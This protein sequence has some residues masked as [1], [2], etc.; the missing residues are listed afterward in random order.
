MKKASSIS[1][2]ENATIVGIGELLLDIMPVGKKLG[3]APANVA[4]NATF[5]GNKS[6]I[7]SCIGTDRNARQIIDSLQYPG[8][9]TSY[10]QQTPSLPTGTVEVS[11]D[12]HGEP[13]YQIRPNVAW[14]ALQWNENLERLSGECSGIAFGTLAQRSPQTRETICRFLQRAPSAVRLCDINLRMHFFSRDIIEN[15]LR[16]ATAAKMN[17]SEAKSLARIMRLPPSPKAVAQALIKEFELDW[18]AITHGSLGTHI[19][20]PTE[21]HAPGS[22]YLREAVLGHDYSPGRGDPVGAGD[23]VSAA[24][25]HGAIRDWPW[26]RTM[27]FADLLGAHVVSHKGAC[28]VLTPKISALFRREAPLDQQGFSLPVN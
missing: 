9:D 26:H 13:I 14:D 18:V 5:L 10:I 15:S 24:L 21:E 7:V 2:Y 23:A 19:Y 22:P 4:F 17:Y 20:T 6:A 1:R 28:P 25:L 8:I 11:F 27:V 16:L 12:V 3:G